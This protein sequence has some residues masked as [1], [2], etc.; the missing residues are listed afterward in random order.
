MMST[1][2]IELLGGFITIDDYP[3]SNDSGIQHRP[4]TFTMRFSSEVQRH[5]SRREYSP[6]GPLVPIFSW[7]QPSVDVDVY[8]PNLDRPVGLGDQGRGRVWRVTVTPP[9]NFDGRGDRALILTMNHEVFRVIRVGRVTQR[10]APSNDLEFP[11]IQILTGSPPPNTPAPEIF[12]GTP[13]PDPTLP[14]VNGQWANYALGTQVA[15]FSVEL[16]TSVPVNVLTARDF[17]SDP[18]PE[19]GRVTDP[20]NHPLIYVD[21]VSFGQNWRLWVTPNYAGTIGP[22]YRKGPYQ[23]VFQVVWRANSGVSIYDSDVKGPKEDLRSLQLSFNTQRPANT[24]V[25]ASFDNYPQ[26]VQRGPFVLHLIFSRIVEGLTVEDFAH[27]SPGTNLRLEGFGSH[28]FLFVTPPGDHR[29]T[30]FRV[31]LRRNAVTVPETSINYFAFELQS[32]PIHID[33]RRV[34]A[35][36]DLPVLRS[37]AVPEELTLSKEVYN[38]GFGCSEESAY[39]LLS[40]D[41]QNARIQPVDFDGTAQKSKSFTVPISSRPVMFVDHLNIYIGDRIPIPE[42]PAVPPIPPTPGTPGSPGVPGSGT[43]ATPGRPGVPAIP[44]THNARIRR[45][46]FKGMVEDTILLTNP[47]DERLVYRP[48]NIAYDTIGGRFWVTYFQSDG[49]HVIRNYGRVEGKSLGYFRGVVPELTVGMAITRPEGRNVYLPINSIKGFLAYDSNLV[50]SSSLNAPYAP[51]QPNRVV[52]IGWTQRQLVALVQHDP[53]IYR[54]WFYGDDGEVFDEGDLRVFHGDFTIPVGSVRQLETLY[55]FKQRVDIVRQIAKQGGGHDIE[56]KAL[57]LPA[58]FKTLA[59]EEKIDLGKDL[60]LQLKKLIVIP[61]F[62]LTNV[63]END[64]VFLHEGLPEEQPLAVPGD[65][66]RITGIQYSGDIRFQVLH[67]IRVI[68]P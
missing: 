11:P 46:S 39:I 20:I 5:L 67:C 32:D 57:N 16:I 37:I 45:L 33:T 4:F 40:E 22:P 6:G 44:A 12:E 23:G 35:A 15:T 61:E 34:I 10:N 36:G 24:Q 64:F 41:N 7:N 62:T 49:R 27:N 17:T 28:Y 50:R 3:L 29:N 55:G 18:P 9:A 65:S 8:A 43:P 51:E 60:P 56:I 30:T 48:I 19:S 21:P 2:R 26:G 14:N 13:D 59:G 52:G 53:G 1:G 68:Q 58:I 47:N 42:V 25:V 38:S 66:F 63:E 31:R 54:M